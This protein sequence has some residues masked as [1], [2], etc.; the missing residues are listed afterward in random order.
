[1]FLVNY[2]F[3]LL[4]NGNHNSSFVN[5]ISYI[6]IRYSSSVIRHSSFVIRHSLIKKI[7]H[8]V[9][10]PRILGDKTSFSM[11]LIVIRKS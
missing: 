8:F 6:V 1:M 9:L 5:R 4:S 10:L 3:L 2:S 11:T 7:L